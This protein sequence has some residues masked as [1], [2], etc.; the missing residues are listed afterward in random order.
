VA[1][2]ARS[3]QYALKID[4]DALET[5]GTARLALGKGLDS[6]IMSEHMS[7]VRR[8]GFRAALHELSLTLLDRTLQPRTPFLDTPPPR[9]TPL[10]I[11]PHPTLVPTISTRESEAIIAHQKLVAVA[12][13]GPLD[14]VVEMTQTTIETLEP[15][16]EGISLD[17]KLHLLAVHGGQF[18]G[19]R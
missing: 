15:Y 2:I 6:V 5:V 11:A 16:S 3:R 12:Q 1:C 10:P 7:L 14:D 9:I 17:A 8:V 4:I 18:S 13:R 19:R